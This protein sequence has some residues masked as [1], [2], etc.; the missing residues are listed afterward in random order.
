MKN[1]KESIQADI[2][3][4]VEQLKGVKAKNHAKGVLINYEFG[5]SVVE[6]KEVI[7]DTL[8]E[9]YNFDERTLNCEIN[10][11]FNIDIKSNNELGLTATIRGRRR[12]RREILVWINI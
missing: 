3:I 2:S 12:D 6:I 5:Q 4:A 7:L 11:I 8:K 9:F 1:F 10:S